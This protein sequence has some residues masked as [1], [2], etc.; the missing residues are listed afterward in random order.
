MKGIDVSKHNGTIDFQKV[1]NSGIEF[2]MIR[3]GF[4]SDTVDTY[5]HRNVKEAQK[6]GIKCGVY[7]FSY[8]YTPQM[9]KKEAQKCIDTIKS[10]KLDYPVAFDFE[11]A[12]ERRPHR[13]GPVSDHHGR[14][15]GRRTDRCVP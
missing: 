5:F 10:Y 15:R 14:R 11:Y 6:H 1:R 7:W 13:R 9:A 2:A 4:G 8:A 12:E 3:A